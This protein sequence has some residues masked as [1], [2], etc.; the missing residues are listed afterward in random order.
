MF[1]IV[2]PED[3]F[4]KSVF[5]GFDQINHGVPF[6]DLKENDEVFHKLA[7]AVDT[8]ITI[9]KIGL[10]PDSSLSHSNHFLLNMTFVNC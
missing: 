1:S 4:N 9:V 8:C 7:Y 2:I 6:E 5:L 10:I 3:F